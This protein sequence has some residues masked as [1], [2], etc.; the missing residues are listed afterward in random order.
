MRVKTMRTRSLSST[1]EKTDGSELSDNDQGD[2]EDDEENEVDNQHHRM[3]EARLIQES[4]RQLARVAPTPTPAMPPA[5]T[6]A[7][8]AAKRL[9]IVHPCSV[10]SAATA[11]VGAAA[12]AMA[13]RGWTRGQPAEVRWE[14]QSKAVRRLRIDVC[15]VAWD[16]PTTIAHSVA[17]DAGVFRWKRVYWGMPI[18]DG[19][20]LN[21][22]D[23]SGVAPDAHK[24]AAHSGDKENN[25][26][27][28]TMPLL[29]QSELFAVVK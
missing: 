25:W 21:I 2:D 3:Q 27:G 8:A 24:A 23:A 15:N 9:R 19:Y 26:P 17:A 22:Y 13:W 28:T 12:C 10:K 5:P 20:Y 16:V 1:W 11:V 18:K 4:S 14:V 29:A 7:V 6:H